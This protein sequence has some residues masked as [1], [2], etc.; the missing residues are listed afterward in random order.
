MSYSPPH[1]RT[2]TPPPNHPGQSRESTFSL[3]LFVTHRSFVVDS[4]LPVRVAPTMVYVPDGAIP[5][6]EIALHAALPRLVYKPDTDAQTSSQNVEYSADALSEAVRI[7]ATM[8]HPS[9][10][11]S[12]PP[13]NDATCQ[14]EVDLHPPPLMMFMRDTEPQERN[15]A[16]S[17]DALS[18]SSSMNH[19][20]ENAPPPAAHNNA[21]TTNCQ[22][23]Y[24]PRIEGLSLWSL[25]ADE[26]W[27]ERTVSLWRMF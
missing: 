22:D 1:D 26:R 27:H 13:T 4:R 21:A 2:S 9:R 18:D 12:L 3:E 8:N 5:H 7:N 15:S 20:T 10:I 17:D 19:H 6:R 25:D 16:Y 23:T 24:M 11:V 14:W